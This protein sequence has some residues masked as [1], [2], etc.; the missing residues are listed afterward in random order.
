MFAYYVIVPYL[1]KFLVSFQGNGPFMPLI[2]S[3][4]YI[5]LLLIVLVGVGAMFEL[6]M[7][8]LV[9]S[10]F[11]IVT[12]QF[13]WKNFRYAII[14]ITVVAAIITPTPDATTMLIFM[15]PM[16]GLYLIG[17]VVSWAVVRRKQRAQLAS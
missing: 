7:V 1:M 14:V 12:P 11:G 15:A 13:L 16:I 2:S 10:V 4:E 8:I 5:D 3:E 17:I 9:L 6:P